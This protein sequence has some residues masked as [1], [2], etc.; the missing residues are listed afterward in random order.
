M[1]WL[2]VFRQGPAIASLFCGVGPMFS[3]LAAATIVALLTLPALAQQA[4]VY[5]RTQDDRIT[6]LE[7]R[8]KDAET[9]L[10][11][12]KTDLE[13]KLETLAGLVEKLTTGVTEQGNQIGALKSDFNTIETRI[14]DQ[15]TLHQQI[16]TDIARQDGS[17]YVPQLSAAMETSNAF[18]QDMEKAVHR[19]LRPTGMLHVNNKTISH[20]WIFINRSEH[21]LRSGEQLA[22]EVPVGTVTTQLPGQE[23]V[24]WTLSAPEYTESIDIVPAETPVLTSA[25]PAVNVQRPLMPMMQAPAYSGLPTY[26]GTALQL[27][28]PM[29]S[30][31]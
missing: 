12:Q 29:I 19:S 22:I 25:L 17:R 24:N 16:L 28:A 1:E 10:T 4:T 13:Q 23:L 15:L 26:T 2:A 18:R 7:K 9:N 27:N 5:D 31:P 6:A 11:A 8:V 14:R 3:R 20:Q 30:Y 21:M